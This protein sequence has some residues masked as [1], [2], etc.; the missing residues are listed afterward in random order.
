MCLCICVC[1]CAPLC[2]P[3]LS[4]AGRVPGIRSNIKSLATLS[5]FLCQCAE[6]EISIAYCL[7]EHFAIFHI[8]R[9]KR[10]QG[11]LRQV[12]TF[13]DI[14]AHIY[15]DILHI[16]SSFHCLRLSSKCN[17]F[18]R[19]QSYIIE[20][21]IIRYNMAGNVSLDGLVQYRCAKQMVC[22][23]QLFHLLRTH[24]CCVICIPKIRLLVSIQTWSA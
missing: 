14:P 19:W 11:Q 4:A 9:W 1:V 12:H 3:W 17:S 21:N 18:K 16:R 10:A 6:R 8:A 15:I 2:V 20:S 22:Y 7:G 24:T 5:N 13:P 23:W